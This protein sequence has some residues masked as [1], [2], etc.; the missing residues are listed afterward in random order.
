MRLIRLVGLTLAGALLVLGAPGTAHAQIGKFLKK[1]KPHASP[2]STASADDPEHY[3]ENILELDA[4]RVA[5]IVAAFDAAEHLLATTQG[6]GVIAMSKHAD[7]IQQRLQETGSKYDDERLKYEQAMSAHSDCVRQTRDKLDQSHMGEM[8]SLMMSPEYRRKV[9]ESSQAI[10]AATQ[11]GDTAKARRIARE[12]Q[13]PMMAMAEKDSIAAEKQC[14]VPVRSPGLAEMD[15]LEDVQ[16][17]LLEAVRNAQAES[18]DLAAK[19]SG[20]TGDQ[21]AY[22]RERIRYYLSRLGGQQRGFD[23][24]E[25]AALDAHRV[26]LQRLSESLQKMGT[27]L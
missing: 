26:E 18:N 2:A 12:L 8:Q 9:A 13:A 4:D 5:K 16:R 23:A 10:A 11:A 24:T 25:L 19:R 1:V 22:A 14:G 27:G 21:F 15:S 6:V 17:R 3:N 7:D 20:L